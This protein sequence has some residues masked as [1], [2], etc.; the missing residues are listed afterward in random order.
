MAVTLAIRD[1]DQ[2]AH[3]QRQQQQQQ[4]TCQTPPP[5]PTDGPATSSQAHM[6]LLP[7]SSPP[8]PHGLVGGEARRGGR[9]V[10]AI[11]GIICPT[12]RPCEEREGGGAIFLTVP[13][14]SGRVAWLED[15]MP[16]PA[17]SHAQSLDVRHK[18]A[19]V[20]GRRLLPWGRRASAFSA[21]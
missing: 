8:P 16:W 3:R 4:R 9:D 10:I 1:A 18:R 21:A 20:R 19:L 5:S 6:A 13:R 15:G 17:A 11:M 14:Q 2:H 12:R 7:S